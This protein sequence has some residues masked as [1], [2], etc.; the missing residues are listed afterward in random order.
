MFFD[1]KVYKYSICHLYELSC[2]WPDLNDFSCF[3][4][5]RDNHI[6]KRGGNRIDNDT[7]VVIVR[8]ITVHAGNKG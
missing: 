6:K 2:P 1:S 7:P 4:S 5:C 8:E 3:C